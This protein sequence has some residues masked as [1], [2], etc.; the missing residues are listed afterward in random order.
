MYTQ[1]PPLFEAPLTYEIGHYT[2]E[3]E[4]ESQEE[5]HYG[6]AVGEKEWEG[7]TSTSFVPIAVE[8]RGGGRIQD[9]RDPKPA[10]VVIVK[11]VGDK[12]IP[13]HRLAAAA[14]QALV[15]E[16]RTAGISAPLLL[17]VSG[18]RSSKR[19]NELW[20]SALQ[21]YGSPSIARRWVAPP[22]SSAHQSGRAIDFYLGGKNSSK[23]VAYLR[24]LP[25]YRWLVANA[26][27]FGFYPYP[28]EPWHWEYNPPHRVAPN[29]IIEGNRSMY[30]QSFPLFEAPIAHEIGVHA[31]YCNC[32][33]CRSNSSQAFAPGWAEGEWE[34]LMGP[35]PQMNMLIAPPSRQQ[36]LHRRRNPAPGLQRQ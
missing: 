21:R 16:A 2:N 3:F 35:N 34:A 29:R 4:W 12:K 8:R 23:N 5:T 26:E 10:D 17:P 11:G 13:L 1:S 36:P 22:G 9:K 27:R 30:T 33:E 19:Q 28:N 24:T 18:Y 20:Q 15:A 31:D 6:P 32:R 14:W 25:A 7:V